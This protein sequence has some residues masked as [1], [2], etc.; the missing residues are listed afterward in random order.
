MP[1]PSFMHLIGSRI[2]CH[3]GLDIEDSVAASSITPKEGSESS[4]AQHS[5]AQPRLRFSYSTAAS[6][7]GNRIPTTKKLS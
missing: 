5:E 7:P 4:T 2:L 1:Q 6:F 3:N